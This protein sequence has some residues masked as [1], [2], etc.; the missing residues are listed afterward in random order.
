[1]YRIFQESLTNISRH[2]KATLVVVTLDITSEFIHLKIVDNGVGFNE[3]DVAQ[4]KT[5]GIIGM[6]ERAAILG[7]NYFINSKLDEGTIIEVKIPY[8]KN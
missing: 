8:K 4:K 3:I 6:K 7:G 1:M 5:L 2:S